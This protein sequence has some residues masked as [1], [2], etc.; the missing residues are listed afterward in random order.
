MFKSLGK[1]IF[2]ICLILLVAPILAQHAW[3]PVSEAYRHYCFDFNWV[4]KL[5]RDGTPL[6]DY[7]KMSAKEH[8]RHLVKL[9]G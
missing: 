5:E 2:L 9:C 7:G 3:P 6:S 4:D 1:R 8:I